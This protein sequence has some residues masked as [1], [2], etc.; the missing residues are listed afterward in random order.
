MVP[1][2]PLHLVTGDLKKTFALI[3]LGSILSF[4]DPDCDGTQAHY[5]EVMFLEGLVGPKFDFSGGLR[6]P[7]LHLVTCGKKP[8]RSP[9]GVNFEFHSVKIGSDTQMFHVD[10]VSQK[11]A[12]L[13]K[14]NFETT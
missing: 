2:K 4:V 1:R 12:C 3:V 9:F 13:K 8:S 6:K 11:F 5:S 10:D 7:V 14:L